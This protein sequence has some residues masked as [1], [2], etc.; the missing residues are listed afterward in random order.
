MKAV[1]WFLAATF[2][3][4]APML[5]AKPVKVSDAQANE[6]KIALMITPFSCGPAVD[7]KPFV[8][9]LRLAQS[10]YLDDAGS[11]PVLQFV[12][13]YQYQ[14]TRFVFTL[15]TTNDYKKIARLV[16]E[17]QDFVAV[18][19]GTLVKPQFVDRFVTKN[20]HE[21]K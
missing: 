13:N 6:L 7:T 4:A 17:Q 1:S 21:C 19:I 11:Q 8:E 12:S 18:N 16:I 9:S 20:K 15:T 2:L 3:L 10:V 14:S 5:H